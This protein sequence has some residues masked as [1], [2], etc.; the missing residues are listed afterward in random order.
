[1]LTRE[2]PAAAEVAAAKAAHVP[3]AKAAAEASYVAEVSAGEMTGAELAA[4]EAAYVAE[5]YAGEMTGAVES[6]ATV[7]AVVEAVVKAVVEVAASDEDR[8]TKPVA[9]VVIRIGVAVTIVVARA[10]IRPIVVIAAV[11]IA[12]R[13]AGDHSGRDSRAGIIA[14]A[15]QVAMSVSPNIMA[16]AC[17]SVSNA[18]VQTVRDPRMSSVPI[19]VSDGRRVCGRKRGREDKSGRAERDSRNLKSAKS[20]GSLPF[21]LGG[22]AAPREHPPCSS[23]RS[24]LLTR[25]IRVGHECVRLE[26]AMVFGAERKTRC[27]FNIRLEPQQY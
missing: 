12:G 18:P 27:R 1:V 2:V 20:H 25:K 6:E 8:T 16:M 26:I 3:A 21:M 17:V 4:A 13:S 15:V 22:A 7:E 9:I 11:R 19:M 24:A 23:D 14:I 10:I 5:V